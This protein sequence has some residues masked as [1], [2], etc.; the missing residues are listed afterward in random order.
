M[1]YLTA[2]LLLCASLAPAAALAQASFEETIARLKLPDP[3]ARMLAL[4]QLQESGYP[5]AGGA[6]A[7]LLSD[8]DD[9]IQR[10]AVYAELGLFLRT[11]V[12]TRRH[13][14]LVVE[15]R[16]TN[17]ALRAFDA[18]WGSLPIS[19][20][21][22]AV[23]T[24]LLQPMKLPDVAFRIETI[25]TLG[26]LGQVDNRR[27]TAAHKDVAEALAERL[28]DPA[29]EVR[30]A[31]ARAGGRIFRRC[32]APCEVPTLSRFGDALVHLL[33]DPDRRVRMAA[34]EGLSDLRWERAAQSLAQAFEY[35]QSGQDALA[36][37]AALGRIGHETSVPVFTAAMSSKEDG[38]RQA[39]AS[40]LAR[41]GGA[42]AVA[43]TAALSAD[44]S[45]EVLAAVAFAEARGPRPETGIDRLVAAVDLTATRRQAQDFLVEIGRPAARA[46]AS[47]V[48]GASAD[49]RVALIEVLSAIG[50]S[51]QLPAVEP[52]Q[53]DRDAR[54]AAAAERAALRL[55]AARPGQ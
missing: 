32:P 13:V 18:T 10:A 20:V 39:A 33:N 40:G 44:R 27:P 46:V 55:R 54:V 9:K 37:L 53:A 16:D 30:V 24:G 17:P 29:A 8:P 6:I 52:L 14:A 35:Y 38:F 19:P 42:N 47:A 41:V 49:A 48:G 1:R 3:S 31:A 51:T 12:E 43:V 34:L 22:D 28:G 2:A 15:V 26:L 11:R 4:R 5:E 7:S 25:Y 45:K 23:V 36:Y 50:D 21:P